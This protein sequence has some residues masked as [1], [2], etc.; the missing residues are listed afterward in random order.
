MDL[1]ECR[2][3][4]GVDET[5]WAVEIGRGPGVVRGARRHVGDAYRRGFEVERFEG[6]GKDIACPQRDRRSR[7]CGGGGGKCAELQLLEIDPGSATGGNANRS[8]VPIEDVVE[9]TACRV[10]AGVTIVDDQMVEFPGI[11]RIG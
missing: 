8:Y 11:V 7:G 9:L 4:A 6:V 10:S 1:P 3:V 2:G 5:G